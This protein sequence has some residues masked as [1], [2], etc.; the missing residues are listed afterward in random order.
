M[1]LIAHKQRFMTFVIVALFYIN[2]DIN[3]LIM[4]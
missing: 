3:T 4:Q 1:P 2:L